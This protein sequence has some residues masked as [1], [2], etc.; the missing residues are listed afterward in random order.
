MGRDF[1]WAII[2][3]GTKVFPSLAAASKSANNIYMFLSE[4]LVQKIELCAWFK[5][6][7]FPFSKRF[8]L[9]NGGD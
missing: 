8:L 6:N 7:L 4:I 1:S 3:Y 5:A 2:D 9:L